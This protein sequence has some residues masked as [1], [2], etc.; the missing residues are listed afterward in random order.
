MNKETDKGE[1]YSLDGRN[2][3]KFNAWNKERCVM[4]TFINHP[5]NWSF[6]FLDQKIYTWLLPTGF[7]DNNGKEIYVG[8]ILKR[9]KEETPHFLAIVELKNGS[10]GGTTYPMQNHFLHMPRLSRCDYDGGGY[11]EVIGN[12]FQNPELAAT[13]FHNI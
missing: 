13:I 6:S 9:S 10:F 8:D 1:L 5:S 2:E 12:I 7:K 11:D 4:H 3:I